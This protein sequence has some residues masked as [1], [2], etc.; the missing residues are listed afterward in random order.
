[1]RTDSIRRK[2]CKA[3]AV[4]F[5]YAAGLKGITKDIQSLRNRFGLN[6]RRPPMER[7]SSLMLAILRN[8]TTT[9]A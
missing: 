3:A 2:S 4:Q 5:F 7:R 9:H 8:R 6:W 1:M